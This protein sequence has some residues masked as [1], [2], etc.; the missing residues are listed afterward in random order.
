MNIKK[1]TFI[2][3]RQTEKQADKDPSQIGVVLH[4]IK[5]HARI[6]K[7]LR[8]TNLIPGDFKLCKH[9]LQKGTKY[10]CTLIFIFIY[11]STAP[12]FKIFALKISSK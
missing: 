4:S 6:T 11:N 12:N 2:R 10:I 3:F 5:F 8:S 7:R 9:L 1:E